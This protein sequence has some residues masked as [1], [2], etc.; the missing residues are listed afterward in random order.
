MYAPVDAVSR[1][2]APEHAEGFAEAVIAACG[3]E[4][5]DSFKRSIDRARL[6]AEMHKEFAS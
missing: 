1:L 4:P 3:G 6:R 5:T 2:I